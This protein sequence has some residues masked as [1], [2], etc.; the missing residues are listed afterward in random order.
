MSASGISRLSSSMA[1]G[2]GTLAYKAP[3]LFRTRKSGGAMVGYAADV[4]AYAMVAFYVLT[5]FEP[6]SDLESPETVRAQTPHRG[7][8]PGPHNGISHWG[9]TPGPHTVTPHR[10]LTLGPHTGAP[11]WG[12]TLGPHTG[13]PHW[14]P[15]LGPHTETPHWDPTPGPH[16]GTPTGTPYRDP[17]GLCAVGRRGCARRA[18]DVP[19]AAR[20]CTLDLT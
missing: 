5:R 4:Y 13:T 9:P 16:I 12:P 14:D 19:R 1:D 7:L 3:E 18:G 2:R 10:G 15:A 11:H 8:T 17:A 6:W 20:T